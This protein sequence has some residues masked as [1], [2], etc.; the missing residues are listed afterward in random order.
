MAVKLHEGIDRAF[1]VSADRDFVYDILYDVWRSMWHLPLI[2]HME[3]IGDN[4]ALGFIP[5]IGV[6]RF[7][8][9]PK[10]SNKCEGDREKG[11]VRFYPV[12]R[13]AWTNFEG[14][15]KISQNG[16]GTRI[17]L[18]VEIF[19]N[20]PF[21]SFMTGIARKTLYKLVD[22]FVPIY[23]GRLEKTLNRDN[24][25]EEWYVRQGEALTEKF[26]DYLPEH[27]R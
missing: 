23:I 9:Q 13:A 12:D 25:R 26:G 19:L 22:R 8:I 14:S 11:E 7:S 15:W 5:K 2:E 4:A 3:P 16:K 6:G 17:D 27:L 1:T 24:A 18:H 20:L 10:F 21:P